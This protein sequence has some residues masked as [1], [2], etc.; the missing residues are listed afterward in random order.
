MTDQELAIEAAH[1]GADVVRSWFGR[2]PDVELKGA[3][4]PVTVADQ[5]AEQAILGVLRSARPD[6]SF[7]TEESGMSGPE[8]SRRWI[9]DPLDGTI[10]FIHG[11]P[12]VGVSVAFYQDDSPSAAAVVDVF[13]D[14]TFS[15]EAGGGTILDGQP[16]RV[17]NREHLVEALIVTGFPYD[18]QEHATRYVRSVA[19]VLEKARGVRRIGSAALDFAFVAAGRFDAFWE[20]LLAP[21]D[22]AAGL[23]LVRE[24]GGSVVDEQRKPYQPGGPVV[25]AGNPSITDQLAPLIAANLPPHMV[26]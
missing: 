6:D 17:S 1:A 3:V 16:V 2:E 24:A 23:L 5:E 11:I 22:T 25:I 21:W 26:A 20:F 9:V 12:H 15:A 4:D 10:N 14:Q 13:R 8:R 18:R 7:L 19:A